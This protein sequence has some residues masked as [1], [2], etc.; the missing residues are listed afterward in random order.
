ML[1]SSAAGSALRVQI[2]NVFG[3]NPL[4][5]GSASVA[6]AEPGEAVASLTGSPPAVSPA[7]RARAGSRQLLRFG[8]R[9]RIELPPGAE[10][11][12]DPVSLAVTR[13]ADL[14]V[15]LHL[16]LTAA[17]PASTHPGSRIESWA[18]PGDATARDDW[19][20]AAPRAGWWYLSALDV[21]AD[22]AAR[23]RPVLVATGDSIT[24]GYGVPL[25]S[26]L[27][28]TDRLSQRLAAAGIDAAVVNTGIGGGRLLREGLGPA[29][30]ARWPR[31]VAG[32]SG[33]THAVVLIGVNDLGAQRRAGADSP[34]QRAA[35]LDELQQALR[36]LAAQAQAQG[37]CL[38]AAT[39]LPYAG[40]GYYRPGP[41]NEA[42]RQT[43]N[44]WIRGYPGF[45]AVLDLDAW[46]QDPQAPAR[47]RADL[48]IGDGLHPSMAGYQAMADA[49]PLPLLQRRCGPSLP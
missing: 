32:R 26:H 8:G 11:W 20:G 30:L 13:H 29:L 23:Q 42:D 2:S 28:W 41:D 24:D 47:L 15:D 34:P 5:L 16:P 9:T 45:A 36:L 17:T 3:R 10:V 19:T 12:S 22:G 6:L 31:D 4:V 48:D 25:A 43:L 21:R 14:L 37:V 18:L 33:I 40:S 35:L 27:R 38:I 7:P 46:M 49:F 39:V 1:R 44:T